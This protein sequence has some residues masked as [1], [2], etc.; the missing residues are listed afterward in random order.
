MCGAK[1]ERW[2]IRDSEAATEVLSR[3]ITEAIK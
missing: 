3:I 2:G 1:S